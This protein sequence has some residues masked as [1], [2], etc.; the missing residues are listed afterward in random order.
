MLIV[1]NQGTS[2]LYVTL[3]EKCQNV[4]NPY[5]TWELIRKGSNDQIYWCNNDLSFAPYYW[6]QFQITIAT[7]SL[8][9]TSG[10]ISLIPGE[11]TYNI[12]ETSEQYDLSLST[13]IGIV[14]TGILIY[15]GTSSVI[16]NFIINNNQSIPV[17]QPINN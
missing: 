15:N 5:F 7:A 9:L 11:Y 6:N 12:Y 16:P 10:I 14:E 1:N 3:Y 8:G 4:F 17:Y 2:N 13:S